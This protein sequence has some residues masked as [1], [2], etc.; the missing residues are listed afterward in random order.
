MTDE[1]H[2]RFAEVGRA[3]EPDWADVVRRAGRRTRRR[4][5]TLA[6]SL[7]VLAALAVPTAVALRGSVVDFFASEPAPRPVVLDFASLDVGAP[8][9]METGVMAE[10]TRA[11]LHKRLSNRRMLTVWVAP[12]RK[13][14]FCAL[15]GHSGG[16]H[17]PYSIP[18]EHGIS[19]QGP[20]A[21]GVIRGGPVLVSGSAQLPDAAAIELRYENGDADRERLTWVSPPIGAG[22]FV[23]DVSP[24]HWNRNRPQELALLDADGAV[25][26]RE[27]VHFML[28]PAIRQDGTPGDALLDGARK[29]ISIDAHTGVEA[30]LW[31]APTADGRM[32][33]WLRYGQGGFGGGCSE[34]QFSQRFGLGRSQGKDVVLLWGGPLRQDIRDVEIR[35]EDGERAEVG[36]IEGMVLYDI[37]AAHF[38]R[39]HRP[40]LLIAHDGEGRE[41]ARQTMPTKDPGSYPCKTPVPIGAG[42][43]ACP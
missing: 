19:I 18:V 8:A 30:A 37:P 20:I 41:V 34:K 36:V 2:E 27:P 31:V 12:T 13:G 35:Y 25:L 7:V 33:H 40:L 32:C 17:P 5:L 10:Q 9:G 23:F 39:G 43:K 22:F 26:R 24:D 15:Y 42:E 11:V 3:G 16:C 6:A 4:R 1:L 14:G 38:P 29:L 28:P 21:N